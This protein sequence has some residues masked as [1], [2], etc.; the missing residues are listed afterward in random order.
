MQKV[1]PQTSSVIA[2]HVVEGEDEEA[3]YDQEDEVIGGRDG[4]EEEV[5][6]S[7]AGGSTPRDLG[8]E[9]IVCGWLGRRR[10]W[11]GQREAQGDEASLV[12]SVGT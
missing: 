12:S 1:C 2:S 9:T 10:R 4:G 3:R 6:G 5:G 8:D 11:C 7:I